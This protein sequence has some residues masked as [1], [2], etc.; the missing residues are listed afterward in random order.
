M[1]LKQFICPDGG[2]IDVAD[3]LK[4]GGC[5]MGERCATRS[6]LRLVSADRKW[7]GKP[8][9]TQ[10]IQGTM[11]AFLK[12]T[13]E[14]AASADRRAFMINGTRAHKN[15]ETSDDEYSLLEEKFQDGDVTSMADVYEQENEIGTLVD[16]KISGSYK[17][18]KAMGMVTVDELTGEFFKTG[19]RKGQ[20][21]TRK[22]LTRDETKIDLWDW[23][24]QLNDYRMKFE[25]LGFPVHKMKI[26][27]TVRDG[28]T[29]IAR[30]RGVI[31]N[32]Y[33]FKIRRIPD[34][35][36]TAYFEAKRQA[37]FQAL[38][39]GSWGDPCT[40]KENWD[41]LKCTKYCEVAEFC[42]LGK[43]L[44]REKE[45]DEMAIKNLSEI[46][47]LPRLG[48][49]RLGI[50]KVSQKTGKEYP[51]EIDYFLLDPSTPI[52]EEREKL[53]SEFKRLF[54]EQPKKIRV[55]FPVSDL[56]VLFPQYYKRYGSGTMLQCKGDGDK[57][58][59]AS[60]EFTKGLEVVGK[61]DMGSPIV[62][63]LGRECIYYKDKKCSEVATLNVLIPELPG[64][65]VWQITTGSYHSIVGINS[66]LE[67]VR[68]IA[69][70]FHMVPLTLERRKQDT[71]AEGK[72]STHYIMQI[73]LDFKL[74]DLQKFAQIDSTKALLELPEPAVDAEELPAAAKGEP[75][76]EIEPEESLPP[77]DQV[78]V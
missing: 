69:G 59:A 21:K 14:Y 11:E 63:C 73:N 62:K 19:N 23:E 4:E 49:I 30:S 9:T 29:F 1:P 16:Y 53:L 65:G 60:E 35:E 75:E 78:P 68:G 41:G 64:A 43:Y 8:S 3:C 48:K 77:E 18:A 56:E 47:R 26:Q 72:K 74:A 32:I 52:P 39:R 33:Y 54:G 42:K 5:R 67:Y 71:M 27:V 24:Y 44:M 36:V 66:G 7:T 13:K 37:L 28:N 50:K 61:T 70:R 31:R 46:R 51:A 38:A 76:P 2:R 20:Q 6:Y 10:L 55:Y 34:A 22:I 17:V 25:K 12:L 15:L 45:S 58:T 57:A 40:A